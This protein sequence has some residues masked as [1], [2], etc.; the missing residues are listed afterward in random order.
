MADM[1][2]CGVQ[3]IDGK[4]CQQYKMAGSKYCIKHKIVITDYVNKLGAIKN[5][6]L[7]KQAFTWI[8]EDEAP[9][10]LDKQIVEE[11]SLDIIA[12]QIIALCKRHTN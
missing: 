2:K 5:Q 8:M 10:P 1:A 6:D 9:L 12:D 7:L 11:I 4:L 3:C